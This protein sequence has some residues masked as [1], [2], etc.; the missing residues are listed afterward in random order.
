LATSVASAR[1]GL[2]AVII[3]SSIWVAVI[4]GMPRSTHAPMMRFC[5]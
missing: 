5:R 4:T 1:V 2:G 3:D